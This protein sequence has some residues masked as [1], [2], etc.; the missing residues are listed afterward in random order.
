MANLDL[1]REALV[2]ADDLLQ[3]QIES[4]PFSADPLPEAVVSAKLQEALNEFDKHREALTDRAMT[5]VAECD[6]A[7]RLL[8]RARTYLGMEVVIPKDY[9]AFLK[10]TDELLKEF[11]GE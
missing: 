8:R 7:V 11:D 10:E 4:V 1:I 2:E 6:A 5:A 9:L 3:E